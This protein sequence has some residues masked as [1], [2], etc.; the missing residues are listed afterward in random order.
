MCALGYDP[1]ALYALLLY[2][3]QPLD[4]YT[5]GPLLSESLAIPVAEAAQQ[6]KTCQGILVRSAPF[7][8]IRAAGARL[9]E[10]GIRCFGVPAA[11]L[12]AL[13]PRN[14]IRAATWTEKAFVPTV[15]VQGRTELIP[16]EHIV[17]ANCGQ[18]VTRQVKYKGDQ[19]G[20]LTRRIGPA[21]GGLMGSPAVL[22]A[23]VAGLGT[24]SGRKRVETQQEHTCLDLVSL[25]P[26]RRMRIE[27]G[28]FAFQVLGAEIQNSARAN[29]RTL[30][31][32][33][34]PFCPA[35]R[36]SLKPE[37]LEGEG[38]FEPPEFPSEQAFDRRTEWLMNLALHAPR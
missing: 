27:S 20:V 29:M 21:L 34:R 12:V 23:G 5:V 13:P 2:E 32:K 36:W 4:P 38:R 33:L 24:T 1:N 9:A 10:M 35:A 18:F 15:D 30:A 3:Y 11:R 25:N 6:A 37:Q 7:A 16:W 22:A 28:G 31:R 26:P 17:A 14:K 8:R 19:S